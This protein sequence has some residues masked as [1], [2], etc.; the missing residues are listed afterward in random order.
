MYLSAVTLCPLTKKTA[1]M[2]Q[3]FDHII[4]RLAYGDILRD[5]TSHLVPTQDDLLPLIWFFLP[6]NIRYHFRCEFSFREEL[7]H[8]NGLIVGRGALV[9]VDFID[10]RPLTVLVQI[11]KLHRRAHLDFALV[12]KVE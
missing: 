2:L 12:H 4:L 5:Q 10:H 11:G 3:C 9:Q 6:H 7:P 1:V 8:T